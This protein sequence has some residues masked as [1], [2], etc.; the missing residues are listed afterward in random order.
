MMENP[1]MGVVV[2]QSITRENLWG[3]VLSGPLA[4]LNLL[5]NKLEKLDT[6]ELS[7]AECRRLIP[8]EARALGLKTHYAQDTQKDG[9]LV[10][11]EKVEASAN[12]QPAPIHDR[13]SRV[14]TH[15]QSTIFPKYDFPT[16]LLVLGRQFLQVTP[17]INLVSEAG[18]AG[19]FL[20]DVAVDENRVAVVYDDGEREQ[21]IDYWHLSATIEDWAEDWA[22]LL[23]ISEVESFFDPLTKR[24]LMQEGIRYF[25]KSLPTVEEANQLVQAA[26]REKAPS[27]NNTPD[28]LTDEGRLL[29][30]KVVREHKELLESLDNKSDRWRKALELL[31]QEASS[32]NVA[33]FRVHRDD[34]NAILSLLTDLNQAFADGARLLDYTLDESIDSGFIKPKPTWVKVYEVRN[35]NGAIYLS[36]VRTGRLVQST[37]L[38]QLIEH[39]L[40]KHKFRGAHTKHRTVLRQVSGRSALSVAEADISK[41]NVIEFYLSVRLEAAEANLLSGAEDSKTVITRLTKLAK[42]LAVKGRLSQKDIKSINGGK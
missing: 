29:W 3:M 19:S 11:P 20:F 26:N 38:S 1:V 31:N 32:A 14:L 37:S 2:L 15:L 10:E 8:D 40:R 16:D 7:L 25:D 13:V 23:G 28:L 34:S 42:I 24:R 35:V 5:K 22:S 6:T 4:A 30:I 41:A 21:L 12:W 27:T 33:A 9:E 39:L 17:R 18:V 36:F